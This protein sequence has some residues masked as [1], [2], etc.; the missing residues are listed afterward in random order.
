MHNMTHTDIAR[1]LNTDVCLNLWSLGKSQLRSVSLDPR[2]NENLKVF[3]SGTV[4]KC[5]TC[6]Q[7]GQNKTRTRETQKKIYKPK[8]T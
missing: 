5:T 7:I 1:H 6:S 8:A 3:G 4:I 2:G